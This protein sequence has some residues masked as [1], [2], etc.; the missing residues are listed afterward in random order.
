[1]FTTSQTTRV[2][3]C[4]TLTSAISIQQKPFV[5]AEAP[6]LAFLLFALLNLLLDPALDPF[7]QFF[8][9]LAHGMAPP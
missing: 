5:P 3:H 2:T 9:D 4:P 7:M 6:F 1:M 8:A